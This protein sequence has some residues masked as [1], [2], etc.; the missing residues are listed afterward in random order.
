MI[1]EM[2]YYQV[3]GVPRD[4]DERAI[5]LAYRK[6]AVKFHPDKLSPTATAEARRAQTDNFTVIGEAYS[7]LSDADKRAVYDK[8]GVQGLMAEA[9]GVNPTGMTLEQAMELY[10]SFFR[11]PGWQRGAEASRMHGAYVATA[12]VVTAPLVGV[13]LG[14]GM[15]AAGTVAG[16]AQMIGGVVRGG[17]DFAWG[18]RDLARQQ[19]PAEGEPS[20]GVRM[21]HVVTEPIKGAVS[22]VVTV[23]L[24][25]VAGAGT[26]VA[27]SAGGVMNNVKAGVEEVGDANKAEK[28]RGLFSRAMSQEAAPKASA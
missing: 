9:Q 24:G 1:A 19:A 23:G 16:G 27:G 2:D 10:W 4:A 7:V 14:T 15:I 12:G 13:A 5:R 21:S 25:V 22:G 8:Y 20:A 3:L 26:M 11:V 17:R 18:A 6:L 28:G